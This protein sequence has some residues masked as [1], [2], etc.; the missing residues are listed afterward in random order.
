MDVPSPR[1]ARAFWH[2]P[3][4]EA[5]NNSMYISPLPTVL[6]AGVWTS[7]FQMSDDVRS[8]EKGEADREVGAKVPR[9]AP[10]APKGGV[11][12]SNHP[13]KGG[14]KKVTK[15]QGKVAAKKATSPSKGGKQVQETG[16]YSQKA[17]VWCDPL[18]PRVI[19][20]A[21]HELAAIA[22]HAGL[23]VLLKDRSSKNAHGVSAMFRAACRH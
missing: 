19:S 23:P 6:E 9:S 21:D 15:A 11:A 13:L 4:D 7:P 18:P 22:L 10:V 16:W 1:P 2:P 3:D 14:K 5:G 17:G 8:P 20:S 12:N